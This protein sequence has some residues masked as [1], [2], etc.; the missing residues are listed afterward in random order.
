MSTQKNKVENGKE[1]KQ[2]L[3]SYNVLIN[4]HFVK[5]HKY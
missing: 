3:Q 4:S 1:R 2:D 5:E